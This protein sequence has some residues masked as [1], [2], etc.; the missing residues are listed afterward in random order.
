[1]EGSGSMPWEQHTVNTNN[2][3]CSATKSYLHGCL[4]LINSTI[5][6]LYMT[7]P[8]LALRL[9]PQ[10]VSGYKVKLALCLQARGRHVKPQGLF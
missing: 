3:S 9:L 1:M 4:R 5:D 10:I 7:G 2:G 6:T 8:L